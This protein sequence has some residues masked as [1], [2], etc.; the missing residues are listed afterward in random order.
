MERTIPNS[1]RTGTPER[2][3]KVLGFCYLIAGTVFAVVGI[4]VLAK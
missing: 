2:Y 4:V 1:L 3:R